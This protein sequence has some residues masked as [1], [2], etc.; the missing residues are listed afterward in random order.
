MC[1]GHLNRVDD[2]IQ[3]RWCVELTCSFSAEVLKESVKSEQIAQALQLTGVSH[4]LQ[5]RASPFYSKREPF[6]VGEW[7]VCEW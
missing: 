6:L 5:A 4:V 2:A 1:L 3:W 7:W